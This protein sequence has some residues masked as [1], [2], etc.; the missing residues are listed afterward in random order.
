MDE[1]S[2]ELATLNALEMLES[3]E[4]RVLHGSCVTDKELRAFASEL[5]ATASE[6]G[7]LVAPVQPPEDMKRRIRTK[8]RSRGGKFW[9]VSPGVMI[10]AL[11]WGLA[12]ALAAASVW[13]WNERGKLEREL[14][15]ASEMVAKVLPAAD[16]SQGQV[17][18]LQQTV[19][20]MRDDFE[21]KQA[22]LKGEIETLRKRE[23]EDQAKIAKLVAAAEEMKKLNAEAKLQ[24]SLAQSEIWE[25]RRTEMTVVWDSRSSQGVLLL[26]K[27]P[28]V[29]SG[30]DYQL[31][32]IDSQNPDAPVSAGVV[33]VDAKSIAKT[34]FQPVSPVS[35]A[36]K[37]AISVENKGGVEKRAGPI[38]LVG[39]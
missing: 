10:G 31:W 1:R 20:S 17:Q 22:T 26:D 11:G 18:S 24:I 16:T 3:D 28:K 34:V 35:S 4:K 23:T 13:L 2:E 15:N 30:K 29:E 25:Y 37:F 21:K 14:A 9:S 12:A 8:I 33:T 36:A 5:E 39:P 7:R 32:I 19:Q 27:M 38:V 6:L